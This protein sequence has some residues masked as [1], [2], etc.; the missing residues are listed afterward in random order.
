MKVYDEI[1]SGKFALTRR[2]GR[3]LFMALEHEG[4]HTETLLY[5]LL[6]RAGAGTIPPP[7]FAIPLWS[8]LKASWD[9]IPPPRSA[10]V[11]LGPTTVTLG[12]DDSE[13][14]D[15]SDTNIENH[16][17]GWDNEHPRRTVNVGKF[18]ISWRP[19]TNGELYSFYLAEGKDKIQIPA[20]WKKEGDKIMVRMHRK[21][22]PSSWFIAGK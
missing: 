5:M 11:T 15:E 19:V 9:L 13:M 21:F 10:T 4:L 14:G 2:A 22:S 20:S 18:M 12:H 16:E 17:F 6:Q 7:G 8:S 1:D 3:Y